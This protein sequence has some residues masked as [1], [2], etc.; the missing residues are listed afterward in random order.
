MSKILRAYV[1]EI[2][3]EEYQSHAFEPRLGDPVVNVNTQCKHYGSRGV[4]MDVIDLP[5]DA[6][7]TIKYH[8]TNDGDTY[9]IGDMLEKTMDQLAPGNKR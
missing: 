7:K 2:I 3:A 9:S 8:V 1:R 5:D 4:V 6:G